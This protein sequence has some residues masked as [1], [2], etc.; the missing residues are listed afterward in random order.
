MRRCEP[1]GPKKDDL[2]T[3]RAKT[4]AE[5]VMPVSAS[6]C[7]RRRRYA[8][9]RERELTWNKGTRL[10]GGRNAKGILGANSALRRACP[11]GGSDARS[12]F[13]DFDVRDGFDGGAC[14]GSDVRS[15]LSGLPACVRP[16]GQL[17][18]MPLHV[19]AS[20]QRVGI[21]P[22]RPVRH[23]SIFCEHRRARG[24]SAASPRLLKTYG[25]LTPWRADV[26]LC[27]WVP[28]SCASRASPMPYPRPKPP[29]G[30]IHARSG[31]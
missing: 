29:A 27:G 24:L 15:G 26:P 3:P 12:G 22:R 23:Q 16:G 10:L 18:P 28:R 14:S 30:D 6:Q 31:R 2:S 19:A 11:E 5:R 8:T 21:G 17:L 9:T 7:G 1:A 20:V 13:G 4:F 25:N